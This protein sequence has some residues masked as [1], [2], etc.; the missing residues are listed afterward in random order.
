M[1][2]VATKGEIKKLTA[3]PACVKTTTHLCCTK[4]ILA[5]LQTRLAQRKKVCLEIVFFRMKKSAI[6]PAIRLPPPAP[7]R[8][9]GKSH[10]VPWA[11]S[12]VLLF[13]IAR[14]GGGTVK[15]CIP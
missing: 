3:P 8:N 5:R 10:S 13:N 9:V 12:R 7:P 1:S 14:G 11:R 4:K 6:L 15:K 2:A